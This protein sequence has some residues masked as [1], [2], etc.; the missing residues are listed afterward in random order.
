MQGAAAASAQPLPCSVL[1][2]DDPVVIQTRPAA[3]S[4]QAGGG[5]MEGAL[6]RPGG[7]SDGPRTAAVVVGA[8]SSGSSMPPHA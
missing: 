5:P 2:Q 8:W 6:G 1:L 4:T 7:A 3:V